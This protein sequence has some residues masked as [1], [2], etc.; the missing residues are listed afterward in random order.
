MGVVWPTQDIRYLGRGLPHETMP[1]SVKDKTLKAVLPA[2]AP[3]SRSCGV[4]P[5]R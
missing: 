2:Q 5:R 4:L 3:A 1:I